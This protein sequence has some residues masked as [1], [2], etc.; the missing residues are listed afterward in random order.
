[1]KNNNKIAQRIGITAASFVTSCMLIYS[2]NV[3]AEIITDGSV[4]TATNITGPNYDISASLGT[5]SGTNLF[6]SFSTFNVNT[7]ETATF[8][9]PS[10]A[11]VTNVIGRVTGG[12]FSNIDG[13]INSSITGASIWLVNPSGIVFGANSSINVDGSFHA[14]TAE[15]VRFDDAT[16]F[17]TSVIPIPVLSVAN[18]EGFGFVSSTPASLVVNNTT[19][20]VPT[21]K[22]LSLVAGDV[23][24]INSTLSAPDGRINLASV[25]SAGDVTFITPTVVTD[26]GIST[27]G[28]TS[29]ADMNVTGSTITTS[30]DGAGEIYIRSGAF[31]LD[32]GSA[33]ENNNVNTDGRVIHI[34]GSDLTIDEG[35][36]SAVTAGSG[37]G[38]DIVIRG[39]NLTISNNV[40]APSAT[41]IISEVDTSGTGDG[42][43]IDINVA[44]TVSVEQ[45]GV[46][47]TLGRNLAK[48]GDIT[49]NANALQVVSGGKIFADT[50]SLGGTSGNITVNTA[51]NVLISGVNSK[52]T[53]QTYGSSSLSDVTLDITTGQFTLDDFAQVSADSFTSGVGAGISIIADDINIL[54]NSELTA[55]TANETGGGIVLT[56]TGNVTTTGD[57]KIS[58]DT[59]QDGAGSDITITAANVTIADGS[60]ITAST[61][62]DGQAGAVN[63][64][65]TEKISV[66]GRNEGITGIFSVSGD[67]IFTGTFSGAGGDI[68]L[69]ANEVV[70]EKG[71]NISASAINDGNAGDINITTSNK[72]LVLTATVET[73]A[74]SSSGGNINIEGGK[75]LLARNS[76]ITAEAFGVTT[77]NA[78]GN[79]TVSGKNTVLNDSNLIAR[80]NAGDGGNIRVISTAFLRTPGSN[81]DA[82]SRT[83]IDGE[84]QI[85]T[86]NQSVNIIP[87][88]NESFLDIASLLGNRCAA[89]QLKSRSSFTIDLETSPQSHNPSPDDFS[90]LVTK[91][92]LTGW[93]GVPY[94]YQLALNEFPCL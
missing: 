38:A 70:V 52:L 71:A 33:I 12:T 92:S 18:P 11:P 79:V 58:S 60:R 1:M 21:G 90:Q 32:P 75:L 54:N 6:H 22:T 68:N 85:E 65:A 43:N 51:D 76:D 20:S 83:G 30:G 13:A 94:R 81:L 42:G 15:N 26:S 5:L 66:T 64:I 53:L 93:A 50:N 16:E 9:G 56:A 63:I 47:R 24:L 17:G 27:T 48:G 89:Q 29:M 80:A 67:P 4:G 45:E 61:K 31:V 19:L 35:T 40:S 3:F 55:Q 2:V 82:T 86:L 77:D 91:Q 25:A 57:S 36:L 41:G 23:N 8:N 62:R 49:I 78:G 73:S 7:G 14:S 69:R 37:K 72:V 10:A 46:I 39:D 59:Y 44:G 84:V 28:T 87:V 34:Q 88:V 74:A